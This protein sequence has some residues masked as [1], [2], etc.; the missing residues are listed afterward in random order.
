MAMT[1]RNPSH[2][3]PPEDLARHNEPA[4]PI[5]D[6]PGEPHATAP[7]PIPS[8]MP[9]A[10]HPPQTREADPPQR[11]AQPPQR[12]SFPPAPGD[13]RR[14]PGPHGAAIPPQRASKLPFVRQEIVAPID[15]RSHTPAHPLTKVPRATGNLD[16]PVPH[17]P[18]LFPDPALLPDPPRTESAQLPAVDLDLASSRLRARGTPAREVPAA[19][20]IRTLVFA[21]DAARAAWIERELSHAPITIQVGRRIRTIIAALLRDPPPRPDVLVV[22]FDAI[23]AADLIEL[24]AIRRDGWFGRLIGLGNVT[25]ELRRSLGVD[26]V[27]PEPLVRDSLLDCVAGTRHAVTTTA[28]PVIPDWDDHS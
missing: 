13:P 4:H 26:H 25:P 14:A 28:C 24:H 23:L 21:P 7:A 17:L 10:T 5:P 20:Q 6:A 27:L 15:E 8:N 11:A 18:P 16:G 3:R 2:P 19:E 9:R 22:D 12:P 1:R